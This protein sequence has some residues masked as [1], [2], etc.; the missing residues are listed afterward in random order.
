MNQPIEPNEPPVP[1]PE[2][3]RDR[4]I[5][6]LNGYRVEDDRTDATE[7]SIDDAVEV[8]ALEFK[9]WRSQQSKDSQSSKGAG[10]RV[11][12]SGGEVGVTGSPSDPVSDQQP[13]P[14]VEERLRALESAV[15][16]EPLARHAEASEAKGFARGVGDGA[17]IRLDGHD[18]RLASVE[19]RLARL[20]LDARVTRRM[21][22]DACPAV[23]GW[24]EN[25]AK[26]LE[27]EERAK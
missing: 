26:E 27:A 13:A 10:T 1:L 7:M 11:T 5:E 18:A 3:L 9:K 16:L 19:E 6:H 8:V 25:R 23:G 22:F 14:T 20:E 4:I 21:L 24:W 12:P 15:R 2:V 17:K